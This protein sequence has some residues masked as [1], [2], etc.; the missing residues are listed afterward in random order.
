[1]RDGEAGYVSG[2]ERARWSRIVSGNDLF[3]SR[4]VRVPGLGS[5][6]GHCGQDH[7]GEVELWSGLWDGVE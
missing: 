3:G 5:G 6:R 2:S 1:M 7:C 4:C